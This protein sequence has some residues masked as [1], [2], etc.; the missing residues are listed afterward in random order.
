MLLSAVSVLVVAQSSSEIPEGLMNNPVLYATLQNVGARA[1]WRPIF[2]HPCNRICEVGRPY[3]ARRAVLW[4]TSDGVFTFLYSAGLLN[5]F[6]C[7]IPSNA[8]ENRNDNLIFTFSIQIFYCFPPHRLRRIQLVNTFS[9]AEFPALPHHV[10]MFVRAPHTLVHTA[11]QNNLRLRRKVEVL[12][13]SHTWKP[14]VFA[15][16]R[17]TAMPYSERGLKAYLPHYRG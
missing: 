15:R 6:I 16:S 12:V 2:V 11:P 5:V 14:L 10:C 3:V 8:S 13:H 1:T 4:S 9:C 17:N 7:I